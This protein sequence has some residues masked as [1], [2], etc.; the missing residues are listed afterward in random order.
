[1]ALNTLFHLASLSYGGS[2]QLKAAKHIL[3][4]PDLLMYWLTGRVGTEYTIA[5]TSQMLDARTRQWSAEVLAAIGVDAAMFPAIQ[6]PGGV[7]GESVGERAGEAG[8]GAGGG[9]RVA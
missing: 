8:G 2:P 6:L 9:G 4:L 5:S 7:R 1:M 3:F